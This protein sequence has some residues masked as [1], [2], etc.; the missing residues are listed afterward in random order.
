M[1][2]LDRTTVSSKRR[3]RRN[4]PDVPRLSLNVH[5]GVRL[6][7]RTLSRMCVPNVIIDMSIDPIKTALNLPFVL[8][9][10]P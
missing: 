9:L 8:T 4:H 7:S 3:Q 6:K 2:L 1:E 10:V 5:T